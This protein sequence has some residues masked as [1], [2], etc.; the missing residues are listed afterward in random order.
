MHVTFL[1]M[2]LHTSVNKEDNMNKWHQPSARHSFSSMC[3]HAL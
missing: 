3:G 2:S 1:D